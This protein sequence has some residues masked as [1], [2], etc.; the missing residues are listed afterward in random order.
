MRWIH[1]ITVAF[2]LV[3]LVVG[4]LAGWTVRPT[5]STMQY[6]VLREEREDLMRQVSNLRD[7]RTQLK[8]ECADQEDAKDDLAVELEQ[9]RRDIADLAIRVNDLQNA[10][11]KEKQERA[12]QLA[13]KGEQLTKALAERDGFHN[14]R[15]EY[16]AKLKG[17][18]L[19][20]AA[21]DHA[22]C[23]QD[24]ERARLD[25]ESSTRSLKQRE[26]EFE[27]LRT[28]R[29]PQAS[30]ACSQFWDIFIRGPRG[31]PDVDCLNRFSRACKAGDADQAGK[32][33]TVL[34]RRAR[35]KCWSGKWTFLEF[36][37]GPEGPASR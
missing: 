29:P 6:I 3:L 12:D 17:A 34:F 16:I 35:E 10:L 23:Q 18:A 25:A 21:V 33:F 5:D 20:A 14:E 31:D 27:W 15:D 32:L 9:K 11:G 36:R 1:L 4:F 7:E 19:P 22:Q 30:P 13:A 2:M 8:Q 28:W 24:L 37:L 26:A